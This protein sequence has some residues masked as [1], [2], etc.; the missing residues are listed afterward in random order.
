MTAIRNSFQSNAR[1][2]DS[3]N[4]Q[5]I[6]ETFSNFIIVQASPPAPRFAVSSRSELRGRGAHECSCSEKYA[7]SVSTFAPPP[8][9]TGPGQQGNVLNERFQRFNKRENLFSSLGL[10]TLRELEQNGHE[11]IYSLSLS[12]C[13]ITDQGFV[14][15]EKKK[16]L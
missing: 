1:F 9:I 16:M 4:R 3:K 5:P 6:A 11:I 14:V 12:I 8:P 2:P 7:F 13:A 10:L 15:Q